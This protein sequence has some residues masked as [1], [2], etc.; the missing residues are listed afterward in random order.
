MPFVKIDTGIL[1]ST[2]WDDRFGR[3]VFLTALFMA[4]PI[5]LTEPTPTFEIRRIEPADFV[6]PPGWYG[7]IDAAAVGIVRR[8]LVE[9]E[10]GLDALERLAA[11]DPGSRSNKFDGRRLVRIDGGFIALNYMDYRERDYTSADRSRRYRLKK[12]VRVSEQTTRRDTVAPR[13]DITQAEVEVE[14]YLTTNIAEIPNIARKKRGRPKKTEASQQPDTDNGASGAKPVGTVVSWLAPASIVYEA[15]Y[16]RGSFPWG[17]AGKALKP[18]FQSGATGEAIAA[19]LGRYL[20]ATDPAYLNLGKFAQ[21]FSN[22]ANDKPAKAEPTPR[23]FP[24]NRAGEMFARIL[25]LA[26]ERIIP[27]Q[28]KAR[29]IRRER[30]AALGPDVLRAY[31]AVGGAERFL[32]G[33]EEKRSFVL[34]DFSQL[35][36]GVRNG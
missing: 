2:L 7:K 8:A 36:E 33:S 14:G 23:A 6:I 18:V 13:R 17:M 29:T 11:T 35:L 27:G 32:E 28:S 10:Q 26:E 21:T 15:R 4:E 16:G 3:D 12:K 31:D 20:E 34:R 25:E 1:N 9:T 5:E 24:V 30:V 19:N 22:W